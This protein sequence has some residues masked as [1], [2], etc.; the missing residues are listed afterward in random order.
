MRFRRLVGAAKISLGLAVEAILGQPEPVQRD[1]AFAALDNAE[2]ADELRHEGDQALPALAEDVADSVVADLGAGRHRAVARETFV[3]GNLE[4][5]PVAAGH[6]EAEETDVTEAEIVGDRRTVA[7]EE[8]IARALAGNAR[9]IDGR[10][11]VVA[12]VLA[13]QS[14]EP[15]A[16]AVPLGP[17]DAVEVVAFDGLDLAEG[18]VASL[19]GDDGGRRHAHQRRG[20]RDVSQ[21]DLPP[22]RRPD[23]AQHDGRPPLFPQHLSAIVLF[24]P[25]A[26]VAEPQRLAAP[27]G[28]FGRLPGGVGGRDNLSLAVGVR[29][30]FAQDSRRC[31]RVSKGQ[32]PWN[33]SI[34]S[35]FLP[36]LRYRPTSTGSTVALP[37]LLR[38]GPC[39]T[40]CPSIQRR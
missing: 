26:L 33:A 36:C 37:R 34:V 35:V 23:L 21:F 4:D 19:D 20:Q 16:T 40:N 5:L 30:Q 22:R 12:K 31:A 18:A 14:P 15:L 9:G 38:A 32:T 17:R 8:R 39:M 28:D 2:I 11:G 6:L 29:L 3:P 27:R 10:R 13:L 7:L 1:P 25:S 24:D